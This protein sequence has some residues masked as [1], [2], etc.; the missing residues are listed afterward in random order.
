MSLLLFFPLSAQNPEN[1][2]KEKNDL[3]PIERIEEQSGGNV[4]INISNDILELLLQAPKTSTKTHNGPAR[5]HASGK[6]SGYRIQIFSDG[7]NQSTLQSRAKARAN[8]VSARLP[9]YRG[10]VYT[11]S[12]SPNWYTHVGNFQSRSEANAA[13]AELKRAFPSFAS[14]MRVVSSRIVILN[15]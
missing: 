10:Q 8:A 2:E 4:D 9:K 7:R 3:N 14:E 15:R 11:F 5:R 6:Q 12:R 13:L 1:A